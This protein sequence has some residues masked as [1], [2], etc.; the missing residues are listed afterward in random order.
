MF[1]FHLV[2]AAEAINDSDASVSNIVFHDDDLDD[3]EL[4]G[5]ISWHAPADLAQDDYLGGGGGLGVGAVGVVGAVVGGRGYL[6]TSWEAK[7]FMESSL[8]NHRKASC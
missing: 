5:N 4:G 6:E 1:Y 3:L 7:T 8:G 2:S